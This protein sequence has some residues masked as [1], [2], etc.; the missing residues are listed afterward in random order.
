MGGSARAIGAAIPQRFPALKAV[1]W[2]NWQFDGVDWRVETSG[3][4]VDAWRTALASP[5]YLANHFGDLRTSP[6][7]EPKMI[8]Q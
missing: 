8:S 6:I 3:G 4:A 2:Y 7:P 1:V 5:A